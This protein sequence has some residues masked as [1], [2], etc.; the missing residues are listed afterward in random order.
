MRIFDP[1]PKRTKQVNILLSPIEK[2]RLDTAAKKAG[3]SL[4]EFIREAIDSYAKRIKKR[5]KR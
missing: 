4:A 2:K 5:K 3:M 1:T